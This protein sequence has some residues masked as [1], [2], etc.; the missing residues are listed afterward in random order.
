MKINDIEIQ[1]LETKNDKKWFSILKSRSEEINFGNMEVLFTIKGGKVTG[2]KIK[3]EG[4]TYNI[5]S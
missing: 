5:G 2:M 4:K 3:Q 1:S